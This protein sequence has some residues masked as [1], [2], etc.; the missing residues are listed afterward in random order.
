MGSAEAELSAKQAESTDLVA[1]RESELAT[2]QA[3]LAQL[4][5]ANLHLETNHAEL[6]QQLDEANAKFEQTAVRLQDA[7]QQLSDMPTLQ[8]QSEEQAKAQRK[9]ELALADAQKL[10]RENAALQ[11]ELA[12][13]PEANEQESP[14]LVSLRTERDALAARVAE[15]EEMPAPTVD[16]DTQE[17]MADLQRRFEMAVDDLRQVKQQK[18][19][20]EE[21]LASALEV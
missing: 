8:E 1:A 10:K 2:L 21:K 15:L 16:E 11:E 3:Q 14:E 5:T 18:A 4:T 13:R 6:S 17:R 9:F 19:Q 20:L 7:E 12:T